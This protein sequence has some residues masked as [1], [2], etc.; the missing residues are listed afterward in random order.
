MTSPE[1]QR[2]LLLRGLRWLRDRHLNLAEEQFDALLAIAPGHT[3]ALR[4]KGVTAVLLG[5]EAEGLALIEEA[6]AAAPGLPLIHRDLAA[7]RAA[8]GDPAGAAE[9]WARGSTDPLPERLAF[10]S[11]M[12]QHRCELFEYP[13]DVTIRYGADRPPHPEL[14]ALIERSRP[15]FLELL[16]AMGDGADDYPDVPRAAPLGAPVPMWNNGW[17]PPLDAMLLTHMLRTGR[18]GR[19][20]EIGSGFSTKFARRAITRHDL[21]TRLISVDPQ[22]RAEVDALCD[23][24][25]RQP[26][27]T[28]DQALFQTLEPGDILFLDSSHRAFQGSDVTVFFLEILPRLKPGVIVH[29]HDIYLPED[30][31]SG[32]LHRMWNE[33]YMLAAALLFGDALEILFPAWWACRDPEASAL[34]RAQLMRGPTD[35][36][37][38]YGVSFWLTKRR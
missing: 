33:Q 8:A 23:E 36:L 37:N 16:R 12:H 25:I 7:A 19:F 29:V 30:Y 4:L 32:H 18:P 17:F 9:A 13:F 11:E 3:N 26:L 27:E 10:A 21:P 34:A 20:I 5:R 24:V 1:N 2:R 6:V 28:V 31:I 15:R 14:N 38:L 22:P 35:G